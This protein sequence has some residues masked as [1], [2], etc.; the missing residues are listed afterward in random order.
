MRP[1]FFVL[2]IDTGISM[3]NVP[4]SRNNAHKEVSMR[5]KPSTPPRLTGGKPQ[6]RSQLIRELTELAEYVKKKYSIKEPQK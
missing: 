6:S 1:Q 4:Q 5:Q 2:R 3:Q